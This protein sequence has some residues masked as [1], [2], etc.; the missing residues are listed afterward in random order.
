MKVAHIKN[1]FL[2]PSETF[3]YNYIVGLKKYEPFIISECQLNNEIF[4]IKNIFTQ[5]KSNIWYEPILLFF[6]NWLI[7]K[8]RKDF[9][10]KSYYLN[11][12]KKVN[13]DVVHIHFGFP[14]ILFSNMIK[15]LKLPLVVSF[16]GYDL[17]SIPFHGFDE[18]FKDELQAWVDHVTFWLDQYLFPGIGGDRFIS[19]YEGVTDDIDGPK[20]SQQLAEFLGSIHENI[21]PATDPDAVA[22]IW[23]KF[24]K[25]GHVATHRHGSTYRPLREEH[26]DAMVDALLGLRARY[27][28]REDAWEILPILDLYLDMA[29]DKRNE[30]PPADELE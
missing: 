19:V 25:A 29:E 24:I 9:F 30:E 13:P 6:R 10:Y 7:G 18:N 17:S 2:P 22:C 16:Y 27:E 14:G 12:L 3:I 23:Y 8:F 20:H 1:Y 11:T 21:Q 15:A 28:V 26:I 4:P 5:R